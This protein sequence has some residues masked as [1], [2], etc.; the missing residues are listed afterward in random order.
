MRSDVNFQDFFFFFF[1]LVWAMGMAR[2]THVRHSE[3]LGKNRAAEPREGVIG[4]FFR[5][6]I[7]VLHGAPPSKHDEE[8]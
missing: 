5:R 1:L 7:E 2:N 3:V 8:E 4:H 6:C